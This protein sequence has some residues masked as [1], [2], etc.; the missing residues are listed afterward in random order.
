M[1]YQHAYRESDFVLRHLIDFD[2]LC[3]EHG[4]EG[5]DLELANTLIDEAARLGAEVLAPLNVVGDREGVGMDTH[6]VVEAPGF[7]AAYRQFAEGGWQS[8]MVDERHGGQGLPNVLNAAVSEIWHAANLSLALCPMLTEGAIDAIAEHGDEALCARYL[9]H[10]ASGEWTGTMNL[11]EPDAGSD[12]AAI[13]ARAVPDTDGQGYRIS[14]QKIFITW[15]DHRMTDNI[16]HLVLARLPDA[17]PGVKGIS[18]FVVPKHRPETPG[19]DN[20]VRCLSV[21]HKLG[22]HASPTCV[23]AFDDAWGELVGEPHQGLAYMFTMMNHERQVV[24]LQGLAITERA[25]QQARL[26]AMERLQ[27]TRRDG[28]R[29]PIIAHPD[30]RRMLM[31]MKSGLEAMRALVLEAA[32]ER[33]RAC[34]AHDAEGRAHHLARLELY[35]PIV[36]GWITEFAQELT[37]LAIQVHG[38]MGFVEETGV[39]QHY[40]DARIL[41]IY[42]GTTGIQA[43]D[44]VSRKLLADEGAGLESLFVEMDETLAALGRAEDETLA[45]LIGPFAEALSRARQACGWVLR[46]AG[47]DRQL[48]GAV[49]VELLMLLGYL[50]G[51]WMH[52]RSALAAFRLLADG[53]GERAF[54]EAKLVTARFYCEHLLARTQGALTSVL[55][56]A[57][58]LMALDAEQF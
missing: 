50:C 17:P 39:A 37:S 12:L 26:Y 56:G 42:E 32:A 15:G 11:T 58:S 33:D 40:R 34:G 3:V 6:G 14:G 22:I 23:M 19:Q 27:G 24:G 38:G 53:E 21:E 28:S 48:A 20:G 35:T 4:F 30:V 55:A 16:V 1:S 54:L 43:L 7:A 13:K 8:L 2:A 45:V 18:L 25:Y 29:V 9:P 57:T 51:G 10:L 47:A 49:S 46:E 31:T 41:T 36:K 5:V 52:A 44:L